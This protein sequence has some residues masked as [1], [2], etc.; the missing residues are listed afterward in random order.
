M[1]A[2]EVLSGV[3][4]FGS[5][6]FSCSAHDVF[7]NAMPQTLIVFRAHM[8]QQCRREAVHCISTGAAATAHE[9][10]T[11]RQDAQGV[12]QPLTSMYLMMSLDS[13]MYLS[14]SWS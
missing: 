1:H 6:Y 8:G 3:P 4:S 2:L 13:P 9:A 10:T 7:L 5:G 14:A 11:A 12:T